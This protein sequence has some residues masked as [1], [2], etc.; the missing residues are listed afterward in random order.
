M[1][2]PLSPPPKYASG[3]PPPPEQSRP[4]SVVAAVLWVMG[5]TLLF[6]WLVLL[7][8]L[9]REAGPHDVVRALGC[10][11]VA[12]ALGLFALLR[13]HAPD[14]AI[15]RFIAWRRTHLGFYPLGILLGAAAVLP[16]HALYEGLHR[17]APEADRSY[18][19]VDRFFAA[20]TGG[21]VLI[22][23]AVVLVG[24]VVEEVLFRG[25]LFSRLIV[26]YRLSVVIAVTSVL[27][28]L[29]HFDWRA[30][31]PIA[32]LALAVGYLRGLSGSLGPSVLMHMTFNAFPI[33]SLWI[34]D[35]PAEARQPAAIP[36]LATGLSVLACALLVLVT[37]ALGKRTKAA[38]LARGSD[39]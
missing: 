13:V 28:A 9:V 36:W 38:L 4:M 19:L 34:A 18:E 27:F 8:G 20:A 35:S 2:P 23:V 37:R 16:A 10:Q 12:Y 30:A 17:L 11:L 3:P 15:R 24:P 31:V 29:V 21:R 26:R 39:G 7:S 14:M 22:A 1:I 32:L 33:V 6:Q 5:I 25:A